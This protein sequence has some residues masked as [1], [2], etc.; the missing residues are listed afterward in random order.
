M[1]KRFSD[2]GIENVD[3]FPGRK[4]DI[5]EVFD[6]EILVTAYRIEL[7]KF[8]EEDRKRSG[9]SNPDRLKLA[10]KMDDKDFITFSGSKRLQE[11]IKQIP[12]DG[13]PFITTIR[14]A[15][16]RTHYFS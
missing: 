15:P 8:A 1:A 7:S 6:K 11:T 5:S 16:N 10:F 9:S 4:I 2:F 3:E 14:R 13:F 12:P